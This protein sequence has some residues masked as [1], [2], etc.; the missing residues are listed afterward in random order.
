MQTRLY[1]YQ[2]SHTTILPLIQ[3]T[4]CSNIRSQ[5]C[6]YQSAVKC[7]VC[8][9]EDKARPWT[10]AGRGEAVM[11]ILPRSKEEEAESSE[12]RLAEGLKDYA[13]G[14]SREGRGQE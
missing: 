10:N 9:A 6:T 8:R 5:T 13:V 1:Y 2:T 7:N 11:L 14:K 3:S 4:K 12:S